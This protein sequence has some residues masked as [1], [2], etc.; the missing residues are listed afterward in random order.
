MV[1]V[2]WADPAL[3]DLLEI[4]DFIARDSSRYA[5]ATVE[6]ITDTAAYLANSPQMGEILPKFPRQIYR[7]LVVGSYR[8][9]YREDLY[10]NRV[11]VMGVIRVLL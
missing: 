5:R 8:L 10:N 7:Q 3:A 9:V 4:H 1:R 2:E 6:K 11:I